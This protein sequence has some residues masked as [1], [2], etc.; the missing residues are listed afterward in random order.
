[1]AAKEFFEGEQE[2][3]VNPSKLPW[4]LRAAVCGQCHNWGASIA[5]VSPAK[6][7]FPEKYSFPV[8]YKIGQPL[9]LFYIE[10][11]EEEHRHHQQYNEWEDSAH[12]GAGI[13]CTTCHAVHQEGMHKNPHKALT[14]YIGDSLCTNC[15][16]T[17]QR[18]AAHRIHTFG[19]CIACH[20]P[21][22]KGNEHSHT[23]EFVS[24]EE[25]LR[26]GGVDKKS[27]SCSGCHHHK[28]SPLEGLI[29]FLDSVKKEDMPVPFTVHSR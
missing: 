28:D 20:M 10:E 27:N 25:S 23:F 8:N 4:Q 18:K 16:N 29:E 12:A 1:M 17:T 14:K 13:M 22:T 15:H 19:S 3:I 9:Y 2:T 7:G 24:P 6:E 5:E 26:A 21:K 11:L